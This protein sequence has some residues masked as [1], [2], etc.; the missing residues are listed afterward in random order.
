ML[1]EFEVRKYRTVVAMEESQDPI[2]SAAQS[3]VK[4]GRKWPARC[5]VAD[6]KIDIR[7][8]R[9]IGAVQTNKRGLGYVLKKG[10]TSVHHN[11]K[12]TEI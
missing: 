3:D 2:V 1:A 6:A 10:N 9:V 11:K 5:E 12:A 8:E 4:T 7:I